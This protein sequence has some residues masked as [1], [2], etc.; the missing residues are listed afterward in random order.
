MPTLS[1]R[2]LPWPWDARIALTR[3]G[4]PGGRIADYRGTLIGALRGR[5]IGTLRPTAKPFGLSKG[6]MLIAQPDGSL[7]VAKKQ[8]NLESLYPSTAEYDS[9]P[10]YRER[11][12]MF[13]PTAGLG[14]SV[15]SSA[16]S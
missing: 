15:Q 5:L 7:L 10:V 6:F 12:F 8:T 4:P 3:P 14:E 11:T 13:R 1:S 2:R 16:G 9:A